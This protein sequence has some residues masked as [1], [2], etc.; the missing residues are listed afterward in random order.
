MKP[1]ATETESSFYMSILNIHSRGGGQI[2][3]I[4][5]N[6]RTLYEVSVSLQQKGWQLI[7]HPFWCKLTF[8]SL[9]NKLAASNTLEINVNMSTCYW[10]GYSTDQYNWTE[11]ILKQ[12]ISP[13]PVAANLS[14][15]SNHLHKANFGK[16]WRPRWND[17]AICGISSGSTLFAKIKTIF[18][19][20]IQY[21]L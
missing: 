11:H 4:H 9:P 5:T 2:D 6:R 10:W 18:R 13:E 1:S 14:N 8:T 15:L 17:T 12:L 7:C 19:E 21:C 20:K 16:Q 3:E